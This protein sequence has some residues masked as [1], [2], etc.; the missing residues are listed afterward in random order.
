MAIARDSYAHGAGPGGFSFNHTCTGANLILLVGLHRDTD[1]SNGCSYNGVGMTYLGAYGSDSDMIVYWGMLNPP[2]GTH[3]VAITTNAGSV[4]LYAV[5]VSYTGASIVALPSQTGTSATGDVAI[6]TTSNNSVIVSFCSGAA[7]TGATLIDS[8]SS[9]SMFESNPL[10]ISPAGSFTVNTTGGNAFGVALKPNSLETDLVAYYKYDNGALTTDS[11]G[12]Y[13]LTD[14]GTVAASASGKVGYCADFGNPNTTKWF[15]NT[16]LGTLGYPRTIST[17]FYAN[18]VNDNGNVWSWCESGGNNIDYQQLKL[19]STAS[20]IV[21]R[22]NNQTSAASIDTGVVAVVNTWYHVVVVFHS[23]TSID[24][25]VNNVATNLAATGYTPTYG[26][27]SF[28]IGSLRRGTP[29]QPYSGMVDETAIYNGILTPGEISQ[30]WNSGHANQYAFTGTQY[31]SFDTS[32]DSAPASWGTGGTATWAHTCSGSNR[33]LFVGTF[34]NGNGGI[35]T[36]VTYNGV[37]MTLID[38]QACDNAGYPQS[39]WYLIAPATGPNNVVVT[40]SGSDGI[41]Q[42]F[43]TSYNNVKQSAQPDS[44]NKGSNAGTPITVSTTTVANN[45]WLVGHLR[46]NA[47]AFTSGTNGIVRINSNLSFS[48]EAMIDSNIN[49]TPAGSQSMT[50]ASTGSTGMWL[51]MA[52]FAPYVTAPTVNS[53]AAFLLF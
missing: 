8:S 16:S 26:L 36:G 41:N 39:L 20:H 38:S 29:I 17:W 35:P 40:W 50:V 34:N 18:V 31:I 33:I 45:C 42:C 47:A 22:T 10:L 24:V 23:A 28:N 43:A 52:S 15:Y 30:L 48:G 53:G 32:T 14:V 3:A 21:V 12:T 11:V 7:G 49:L 51:T 5:S 27:T 46:S 6:T 44:K 37:A 2:T 25:Y 1:Q 13:T 19:D 9:W 4:N